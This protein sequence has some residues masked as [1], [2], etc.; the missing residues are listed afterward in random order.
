M[1][2]LIPSAQQIPTILLFVGIC[3][4]LGFGAL[5]W[6]PRRGWVDMGLLSQVTGLGLLPPL[7]LL[8]RLA[9]LP[10]TWWVLLAAAG[11]G[12]SVAILRRRPSRR[13]AKPAR[14][15]PAPRTADRGRRASRGP[16]VVIAVLAAAW[17]TGMLYIGAARNPWLEDDDSWSHAV[18]AHYVA[19]F[20]TTAQPYPPFSHYLEPYPPYYTAIMGVL[21]QTQPDLQWTLK[22]FNALI[23]GLSLIAAFFAFERM[24][25]DSRKAAAATVILGILP[26]YMSHF[27]WSQTLAVPVF[28]VAMWACASLDERPPRFRD[29]AFWTAGVLVWS[30]TIIQ[31]STA[32]V[33]AR[34]RE[35]DFPVEVDARDRR[36]RGTQPAQLAVPHRQLRLATVR[37]DHPHPPFDVRA[38]QQGGLERRSHLFPRRLPV[39]EGL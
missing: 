15:A 39:P 10:L 27:I 22:F 13:D 4:G 11:L 29:G 20:E 21:H 30:A 26:A 2:V 24:S 16:W 31:P 12:S 18:G 17:L 5:R 35:T 7:L 6:G 38:G 33:F 34:P 36:W 14:A 3:L 8:L 37:R 1:R 32:A 19:K 25:G 28:F 9:H 23:V